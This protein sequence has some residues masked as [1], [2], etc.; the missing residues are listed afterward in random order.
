MQHTHTAAVDRFKCLWTS[1]KHQ[2][3][4][5]WHDGFLNF[6]RFNFRAMLYD[7]EN[8]LVDDLFMPKQSV[9]SGNQIEFDHH[10]VSVEDALGTTYT[11]I[12]SLYTRNH[13]IAGTKENIKM[14]QKLPCSRKSL[15]QQ[16]LRQSLPKRST[17]STT[18]SR[19]TNTF[20]STTDIEN[21][22]DIPVKIKA[23]TRK[24]HSTQTITKKKAKDPI[25]ETIDIKK[26][27]L[28]QSVKQK[29]IST[30]DINEIFI[31]DDEAYDLFSQ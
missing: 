26:S 29:D 10:L 3:R 19:K 2:V 22:T 23:T 16:Q 4:K 18:K 24:H 17:F 11:D 27:P 31:S 13:N 25:V 14:P 21:N 12:S 9:V 1:N 8:T 7:K 28:E 30:K 20:I 6:H 5:R 15:K